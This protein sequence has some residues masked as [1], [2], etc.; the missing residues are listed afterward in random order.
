MANE[1]GS[2]VRARGN[3]DLNRLLDKFDPGARAARRR[4]YFLEN[5]PGLKLCRKAVS[6]RVRFMRAVAKLGGGCGR[7]LVTAKHGTPT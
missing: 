7:L 2:I 4:E 5:C 6:L 1:Y 3:H